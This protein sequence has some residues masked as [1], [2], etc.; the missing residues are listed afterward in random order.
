MGF[1]KT[2]WTDSIDRNNPLP[3]YPRPQMERENWMSMNGVYDY[4]IVDS[5]VEWVDNFDYVLCDV[6]CSGLGVIRRKPEIKYTK[7]DDFKELE[8]I[9]LAIVK[10]ALRYLKKGGKLLYSTCTYSLEENEM[11]IDKFLCE[12]KNFELVER[13]A[14][15]DRAK[16]AYAVIA[17]GETAIYANI[18]LKKGVVIQ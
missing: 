3:E 14:F 4:A 2:R 15:Y 8:S 5:S 9:Q 11:C 18:I 7:S 6:P 12:N 10:N 13:F 16:K 17:T 1:L